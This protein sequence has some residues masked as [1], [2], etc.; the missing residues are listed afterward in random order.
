VSCARAIRNRCSCAASGELV[1][2]VPLNSCECGR[3]C[4]PLA[5][6]TR[7]WKK[8]L[9]SASATTN[10]TAPAGKC[11]HLVFDF[12]E[13]GLQTPLQIVRKRATGKPPFEDFAPTAKLHQDLP[14]F[15][16][17]CRRRNCGS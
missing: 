6:T 17:F 12:T 9:K 1:W 16:G 14:G 15:S 3:T 2:I 13:H 8:R 11:L 4:P 5:E 10:L 7:L